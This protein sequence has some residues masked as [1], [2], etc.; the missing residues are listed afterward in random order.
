M[1]APSI[2]VPGQN[3]LPIHTRRA[4][5][6]T[7]L[8]MAMLPHLAEVDFSR[9]VAQLY[10]EKQHHEDIHGEDGVPF[11]A[12]LQLDCDMVSDVALGYG[13]ALADKIVRE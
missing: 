3:S 13:K 10:G 11:E 4:M 8:A 1:N 2:L 7:E 6:A 9:A 12:H 5:V